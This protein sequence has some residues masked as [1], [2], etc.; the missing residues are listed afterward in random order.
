MSEI[1]RPE[2]TEYAPYFERYISLVPD[3]GILSILESQPADV[4]RVL[5]AVPEP[6]AGYRYA[7]GKWSLRE[8]LGHVIDTERIFGY[9]ALCVARGDTTPLPSFD[10][11]VFGRNSPHDAFPL[12]ELLDEFE[13]VRKGHLLLFRHLRSEDWTRMGVA[14]NL[15]VSPRALAYNMAGH[16]VHHLNGLRDNYGVQL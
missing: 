7:E 16:V 2:P 10:E 14:N 3:G 9:R 13:T 11:K 4:R 12:A 5:G 8:V 15:P 6:Q 1:G